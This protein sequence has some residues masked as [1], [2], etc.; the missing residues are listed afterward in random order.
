MKKVLI[1]GPMP[2]PTTG[3]SLANK[4]VVENFKK[5]EIFKVQTINTSY[6]KFD[7]KLGV[8]SLS[9][10]LFFLKLNFLAYKIFKADTIYLTP[11]QT[12]F[13]VAKYTLFILLAKLLRKEIIAHIHGNYLGTEFKQL[14]GVKKAAFKS[15]LSHTNKGIV[16]SE[17][18]KDNL[19]PFI[20]DQN[21]HVLFNF[22]EDYLFTADNP[23]DKKII[24]QPRII[25]LSNLMEEK[26]IFDLLEALKILE[27]SNVNFKAKIAGNID[28][29]NQN[30]CETYFNSL[31]NVKYV[32]VVGGQ[33]KKEL[34]D[35]G[36]IFILPT[37]YKMEGQPISILEAMATENI[38]LTT[39]HAGIPDVFSD[40]KNGFYIEKRNP[41][42]IVDKIQYIINNEKSSKEIMKE[43]LILANKKHKVSNFISNLKAIFEA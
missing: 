10:A 26:G 33:E 28:K 9:K 39:K 38:V 4:V 20:E 30:K 42:D 43:N 36:K 15:L 12:F 2:E 29:S 8:F 3:V 37:Y 14:K 25:F 23:Q 7:D 24:S 19:T 31:K 21:I 18:L 17:S 11:G 22:V 41:K 13:G 34:L 35:W 32:G 1:I 40:K 5:H 6:N 27:E 16:L